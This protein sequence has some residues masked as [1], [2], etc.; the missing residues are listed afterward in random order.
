[1]WVLTGGAANADTLDP[2]VEHEPDQV[3]EN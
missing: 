2:G 1:M 3:F